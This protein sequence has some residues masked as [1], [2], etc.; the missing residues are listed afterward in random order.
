MSNTD[1]SHYLKNREMTAEINKCKYTYCHF[2]SPEYQR[3]E[4]IL[5]G[6]YKDIFSK[7]VDDDGVEFQPHIVKAVKRYAKNKR[8]ET[9]QV[10]AVEDVD[11]SDV[12]FRVMTDEHIPTD[13]TGEPIKLN[14]PA[15][16]HYIVTD[17]EKEEVKEVGKSHHSDEN[18][19]SMTHGKTSNKLG[20]IY[21]LMVNRY[22]GRYNWRGYSYLD[23]M[24]GQALTQLAKVGLMFN[25]AKGTD[26]PNPFAYYTTIIKRCFSK[27]IKDEKRVSE[28]RD[29]LLMDADRDPSNAKQLELE[30]AY[31][32][33]Y[34]E[35]D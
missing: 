26:H 6:S 30:S 31:R 10:M 3:Y 7:A 19:F 4:G 21:L 16:K 27:V 9:G 22:G 1:N 11:L 34:S 15:F 23:D 12:V 18:T 35:D 14:F 5:E 28:I 17:L 13:E 20:E 8:N 24:K 29:S 33:R 32:N 25:E 2:I